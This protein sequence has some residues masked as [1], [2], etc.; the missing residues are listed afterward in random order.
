MMD[1]PTLSDIE[2]AARRIAPLVRRTPTVLWRPRPPLP[3]LAD[4]VCVWLKLEQLQ[5]GGSFKLRGAANALALAEAGRPVFTAS[6]GNHGIGV[7]LAASARGTLSTVYL[8]ETAPASSE[9]RL[10][11]LGAPR[12]ANEHRAQHHSTSLYAHRPPL[13]RLS[14]G[15]RECWHARI[16]P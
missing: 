11:G 14:V 6:G 15:L 1:A 5:R 4:D 12:E 9:E 7:A 16:A 2:A 3:G 10:L 8:P 13:A